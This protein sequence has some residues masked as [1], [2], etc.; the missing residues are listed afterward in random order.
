MGKREFKPLNISVLT[1]SDTRTEM[2]I[3]L[4]LTCQTFV[5]RRAYNEEKNLSRQSVR[6]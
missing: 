2:M 5:G 6:D 1:V 3:S 4:R